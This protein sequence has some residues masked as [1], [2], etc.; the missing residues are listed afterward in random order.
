MSVLKPVVALVTCVVVG[1]ASL[2]L[3]SQEP[4]YRTGTAIV[5]VYATV[6]DR[7][8]ATVAGLTR[9]DFQILDEGRP[10]PVEV[11]ASDPQAVAVALVIDVRDLQA[12]RHAVRLAATRFLAYLWPTDMA[13]VAIAGT[14][15]A[16]SG[17]PTFDRTPLIAMIGEELPAE[18]ASLLW[19]SL[20]RAI[21][22]FSLSPLRK[23][24][25]VVSV[26]RDLCPIRLLGAECSSA[27]AVRTRAN[28]EDVMIYAV[29]MS[30]G[31]FEHGET[32]PCI[33]VDACWGDA[34]GQRR[35]AVDDSLRDVA[36][37]TGGQARRADGFDELS[38][39]LTDIVT[40]VRGQYLLGFR[41]ANLDGRMHRVQIRVKRPDTT[42][43]GRHEYLARP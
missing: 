16:F 8:G 33:P 27:S 31:Y 24:L 4:V 19:M 28:R 23:V 38:R 42:V 2:P 15:I 10:V 39:S 6:V 12:Q 36:S 17:P 32:R 25:V 13:M 5:P 3:A 40:E 18:G 26:G 29:R 41:P 20:D 43:R 37:A 9:D 14:E 1:G 35:I 21:D 34:P 30:G 7:N 11:F 22:G